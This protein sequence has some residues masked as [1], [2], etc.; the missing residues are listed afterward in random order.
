MG[1]N[2]PHYVV[3]IEDP[4]YVIDAE[5]GIFGVRASI[6][7]ADIFESRAAEYGIDVNAEGGWDE[8]F[9]MVFG[10][11]EHADKSV[12]A[13]LADPDHLYNAPTVEHARKVRVTRLRKKRG[14]GKLRG[15]TGIAETKVLAD[16]ALGLAHSGT[17]DPLEFIKRTAPMSREHI[18]VKQEFVRR[19]RN[20]VRAR[21]QGLNPRDLTDPTKATTQAEQVTR[22]EALAQQRETADELARRL[23]GGG[24]DDIA[25][26]SL[27]P[28][29]GVP[30]KD[31]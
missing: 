25:E 6:M 5:K 31:L 4:R 23:L 21:R 17:E 15:T 12:A 20:V 22:R 9:E 24:L 26:I 30:S 19:H 14:A 8:V 28:R 16:D 1:G 3:T 29:E 11:I 27:P 7:P 10:D 2:I 13:E 18:R